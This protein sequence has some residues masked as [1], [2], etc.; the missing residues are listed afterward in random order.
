M[1]YATLEQ[2][3]DR[4]GEQLLVQLTDRAQPATGA[5]DETIVDRALADADAVIDGYLAGR[6]RLPIETDTPALLIDLAL[7]IAIYKL[8]PYGTDEKIVRDYDQALKT[9]RDISSGAIRLAVAGVE[10]ATSGA[11]GVQASD[12]PRDLT[13][14]NLK[15]FI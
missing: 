15:G 3:T 7:V 4:F 1:S 11:E 14:D 12:R 10:A 2:L 6:Y 8:H 13:P 9:L 5:I